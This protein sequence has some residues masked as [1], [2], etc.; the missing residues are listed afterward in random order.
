M[1]YTAPLIS[2][3]QPL[4]KCTKNPTKD[5]KAKQNGKKHGY[6]ARPVSPGVEEEVYAN[7][8]VPNAVLIDKMAALNVNDDLWGEG[9]R[10]PNLPPVPKQNEHP[11]TLPTEWQ[12]HSAFWKLIQT[13]VWENRSM[14]VINVNDCVEVAKKSKDAEVFAFKTLYRNIEAQL[15]DIIGPILARKN[16][17]QD[18][19]AIISHI[20]ALGENWY[21]NVLQE[22]SLCEFL[23]DENEYQD[24]TPVVNQLMS[25]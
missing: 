6:V 10:E 12:I 2:F 15:S 4:I 9:K 3:D 8:P 22:P 18:A 14:R 25:R 5:K 20:I 17:M 19:P 23:I 16:K 13:F 11:D 1:N 7:F 21:E 24:F